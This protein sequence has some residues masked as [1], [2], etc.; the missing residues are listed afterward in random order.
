VSGRDERTVLFTL[1]QVISG[2][3]VCIEGTVVGRSWELSAG[4][5]TIG[6]SLSC[7]LALTNEPGVSKTHAK[8]IAEGD[9]YV[10]TDTE[11]RNGT[12]VNGRPVQK[13]RLGD[14]DEIRVCGCVLRFAVTVGDGS[15]D[16]THAAAPQPS[17]FSVS[18]EGFDSGAGATTPEMQ[19]MTAHQAQASMTAPPPSTSG[20][21]PSAPMPTGPPSAPGFPVPAASSTDLAPPGMDV[22]PPPP[23]ETTVDL[24]LDLAPIEMPPPVVKRKSAFPYFVAGLLVAVVGGGAGF[25]ALK[26]GAIPGPDDPGAVGVKDPRDPGGDKP[27]PGED[28]TGD[29]GAKPAVADAGVKLAVATGDAGAAAPES[30]DD[31]AG[32]KLA[33]ATPPDDGS[34]ED[35]VAAPDDPKDEPDLATKTDPPEDPEPEDPKPKDPKPKDPKP[36]DPKPKDPKP[37]AG[38]SKWYPVRVDRPAAVAVKARATGKVQSVDVADGVSVSKGQLL[39]AFEG[40]APAEIANLK[41]SI[42]ALEAVADGSAEAADLL[43]QERSKLARLENRAK[44]A[45][46]TAPAAGTLKGFNV[47]PGDTVRARQAVGEI[48]RG[49]ASSASAKV[50]RAVG[51]RLKKGG[52]CELQ[53]A[54]GGGGSCT[55]TSTRKR[56]SSYTVKLDVGGTSLDDVEKVRF[57]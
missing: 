36:K 14:G 28:P 35:P 46:V 47:A 23:P 51:R 6:R 40:V 9:H 11:S 24:D 30:A 29:D 25:M 12:I 8:I 5:F 44:N 22:G 53:L 54:G 16:A 57:P 20:P 56:G 4:T 18:S 45:K 27:T 38:P 17:E 39:F 41:E 2:Q 31:D 10:L 34:P 19:D 49:G 37:A 1:P 21:G 50:D 7:D 26:S 13:V 33:A 43:D 32:V 15:E 52:A 55:I 3:L 42:A 48:V